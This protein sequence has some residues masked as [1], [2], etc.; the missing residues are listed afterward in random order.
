M[1][2]FTACCMLSF[3]EEEQEIVRTIIEELTYRSVRKTNMG[4]NCLK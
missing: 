3:I 1:E 2:Y 4:C